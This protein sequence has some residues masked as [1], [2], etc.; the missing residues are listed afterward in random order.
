VLA[1]TAPGKGRPVGVGV[2]PPLTFDDQWIPRGVDRATLPW[3]GMP[4]FRP[5]ARLGGLLATGLLDSFGMTL[6]WTVF[7]LLVLRQ[8]GLAGLGACSAAML[9]GVAL[10]AP[11]TAWLSHRLGAGA[12]LRGTS[13]AEATLRTLGFA[14]LLSGA[15]LGALAAVVAVAYAAGLSC[16]AGM[17]AEVDAASPRAARA[18]PGAGWSRWS[19][20]TAPPRCRCGWSP[21]APG[22][23]GRRGGPPGACGRAPSCRCWPGR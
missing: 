3:Q 8:H 11:L 23:A 20:S 22:S 7:S 21:A 18:R 14:L 5:P 4:S 12:L 6:G 1:G 13:A 15:T 9:V 19:P 17:R 10:S 16:Y 2:P